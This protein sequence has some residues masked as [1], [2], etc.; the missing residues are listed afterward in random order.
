MRPEQQTKPFRVLTIDGG[1][2]RGL[3][4]ATVLR[5][6]VSR[7][8]KAYHTSEADIGGAF[9]LICGTSTGSIL[10]CGLAAGVSISTL[11]EL[12]VEHGST[13]FPAPIP[14]SKL[15][16]RFGPIKFKA[17]VPWSVK[18]RSNPSGS[19]VQLKAVLDKMFH[20]ETLGLLYKRRN[21][22]LCLPTVN[23]GTQQAVVL[24]TPHD[25]D[26][27]RDDSF[28]LADVCMASSAAPIFLPIHKMKNP[29][30]STGEI[31]Y[32]DG[33][34]WAN[35]PVLIGLIEALHVT[36]G[37][38][39]IQIVSVGTCNAPTGDP[40][41]I[42]DPNWGLMQWKAG[43]GIV[44]MSMSAQSTGQAFAA[45]LLRQSLNKMGCDIQIVRL[46]EGHKS[47]E[48]CS[49]IGLDRADELSVKTLIDLAERDA[50]TIYSEARDKTSVDHQII[51]DIFGGMNELT[52]NRK[53]GA[54]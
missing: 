20:D 25:P 34:L 47:P 27:H 42:S 30:N 10:A 12:Y 40:S 9:D 41:A 23:A 54:V 52:I 46:H 14:D 35:N 44:E 45:R 37:N 50:D 53:K 21:I 38:R 31:N 48:Q 11:S 5:T 18:H 16:K 13:I 43:V 32:V 51:T 7:Y 1:G 15:Q 28:L 17:L 4:S 2:M 36:G 29:N 19:A 39:P 33:G 26:K 22:G 49:V 24:K 8:D 3:Y 6:L